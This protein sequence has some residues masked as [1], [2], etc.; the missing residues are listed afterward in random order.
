MIKR[1]KA[2]GLRLHAWSEQAGG[3]FAECS[4]A[5]GSE[6]ARLAQIALAERDGPALPPPVIDQRQHDNRSR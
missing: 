5:A 4:P 6:A 2:G 1:H 3:G